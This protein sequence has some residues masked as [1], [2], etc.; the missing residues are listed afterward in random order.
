MLCILLVLTNFS[1]FSNSHIHSF[2]SSFSFVELLGNFLVIT[3]FNSSL[4]FSE[5]IRTVIRFLKI[6][7][8]SSF[9]MTL[10]SNQIL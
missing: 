2:M 6:A 3:T 5:S 9:E 10:Y 7:W 4:L 1:Y 8:G